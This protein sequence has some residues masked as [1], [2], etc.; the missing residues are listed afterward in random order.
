MN[1]RNPLGFRTLHLDRGMKFRDPDAIQDYRVEILRIIIH[2]RGR[3]CGI[4]DDGIDLGFPAEQILNR[5]SDSH[6]STDLDLP[7]ESLVRFPLEEDCR[8]ERTGNPAVLATVLF[9]D[10][11]CP[12]QIPCVLVTAL[13]I[14][15]RKPR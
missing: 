5:G 6:L 4:E 2:A 10:P 9:Q 14:T 15:K 11:P 8:R 1:D 7:D 13:R 12:V 3:Q